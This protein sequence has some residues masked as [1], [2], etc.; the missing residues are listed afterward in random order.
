MGGEREVGE[1]AHHSM[2][3]EERDRVADRRGA[4]EEVYEGGYFALVCA[5]R[6]ESS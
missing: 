1:G 2:G 6:L 3:L 5:W 4:A